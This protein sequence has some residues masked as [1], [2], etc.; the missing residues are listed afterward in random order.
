MGGLGL[1]WGCPLAPRHLGE[2]QEGGG[3]LGGSYGSG[4]AAGEQVGKGWGVRVAPQQPQLSAWAH[5]TEPMRLRA[6]TGA[7]KAAL[8]GA[9]E[10]RGKGSALFLQLGRLWARAGLCAILGVSVCFANLQNSPGWCGRR[11]RPERLRSGRSALWMSKKMCSGVGAAAL[12]CGDVR[13]AGSAHQAAAA[14]G[15]AQAGAALCVVRGCCRARSGA[16]HLRQARVPS[17]MRCGGVPR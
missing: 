17:G 2:R 9:W 12:G 4:E 7:P 14:C 5:L 15:Q 3:S 11:R 8:A 16:V 6:T 10:A 1:V 13:A